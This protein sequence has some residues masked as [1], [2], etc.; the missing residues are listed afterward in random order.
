MFCKINRN[1]RKS[2]LGGS[3][4]FSNRNPA[5][6]KTPEA[7]ERGRNDRPQSN[8]PVVRCSVFEKIGPVKN[9]SAQHGPGPVQT[10]KETLQGQAPEGEALQGQ[11][12]LP[13]GPH[14]GHQPHGESRCWGAARLLARL[15]LFPDKRADA[16]HD[17]G[18][19]AARRLQ[20][21]FE[22]ESRQ[23]LV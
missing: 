17:T 6:Q 21:V 13:V 14:V 20:G 7:G 1:N 16:C 22:A 4:A 11:R 15:S 19:A 12:T 10:Q 5:Y 9:V 2:V 8:T 3:V 18:D 23:P